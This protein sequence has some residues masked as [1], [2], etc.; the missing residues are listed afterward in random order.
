[1]YDSHLQQQQRKPETTQ[2]I[3]T[4]KVN[5]H[6]CSDYDTYTTHIFLNNNRNPFE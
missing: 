2:R 4:F 6:M 3:R 5:E 1:M